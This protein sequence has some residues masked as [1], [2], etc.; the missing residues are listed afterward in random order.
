[1][2]TDIQ[3]ITP[4]LSN[5][6]NVVQKYN[7]IS[8]NDLNI[9]PLNGLDGFRC[10]LI[11][12]L[13]LIIKCHIKE[14]EE[15]KHN[16][17][18]ANEEISSII[19]W[20]MTMDGRKIGKTNSVVFSLIPLNLSIF[21]PQNRECQFTLALWLGEEKYVKYLVD[22]VKKEM[23]EVKLNGINYNNTLYRHKFFWVSDLCSLHSDKNLSFWKTMFNN[24]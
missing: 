17:Y 2:L 4:S 15:T 22:D 3:Y 16:I 11:S 6:K 13:L 10:S 20:K 23:D 1:M 5:I 21:N 19:E 12:L 18:L 8:V 7:E 9:I 24:Y 14:K